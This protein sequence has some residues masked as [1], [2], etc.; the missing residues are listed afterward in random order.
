MHVHVQ[1]IKPASS[2]ANLLLSA[3]LFVLESD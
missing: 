2:K 1:V 3:S